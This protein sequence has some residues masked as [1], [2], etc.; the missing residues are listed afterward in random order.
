MGGA[1]YREALAAAQL[2]LQNIDLLPSARVLDA[3][4]NVHDGS[5][6]RFVRVRSEAA[7]DHLLALP[8]SAEWRERFVAEAQASI[9]EQRRMERAD[10]PPFEA[11][12]QAYLSPATLVVRTSAP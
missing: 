9:D 1:A 12:R 11:F 4:R 10:Q 6:A 2:G 7:R 8:F 3:M 5:Y